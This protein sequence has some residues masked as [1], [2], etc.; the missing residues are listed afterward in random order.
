MKLRLG[1]TLEIGDPIL[2]SYGS[3]MTFALF[4]GYGRGT[5]QYYTT[6]GIIYNAEAAIRK[7]NK[8][9]FYKAY[10]HGENTEYRVAKVT[11]DI[12]FNEEDAMNQSLYLLVLTKMAIMSSL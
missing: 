7:G 12:L 11:P 9:K 6:Y 8:P 10:I 5:I 2:V 1:G 4:A 3:G